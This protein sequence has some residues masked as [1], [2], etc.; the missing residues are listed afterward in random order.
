MHQEVLQQLES[1]G[2]HLRQSTSPSNDLVTDEPFQTTTKGTIQTRDDTMLASMNPMM[3]YC[4]DVVCVGA[5][6]HSLHFVRTIG[7][8]NRVPPSRALSRFLTIR[9]STVQ[10][11]SSSIAALHTVL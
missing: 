4:V 5:V 2:R 7:A 1:K 9:R 3:R 11:S 8:T 6:A 10:Y